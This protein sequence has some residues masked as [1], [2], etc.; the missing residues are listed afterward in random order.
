MNSLDITIPQTVAEYRALESLRNETL[1]QGQSLLDTATVAGRDLMPSEA[2]K[3][4]A[5]MVR[6]DSIRNALE[7][8]PRSVARQ[9]TELQIDESRRAL[10]LPLDFP[11]HQGSRYSVNPFA[12]ENGEAMRSIELPVGDQFAA[13]RT[14]PDG[15][16]ENRS[17]FTTSAG[18]PVPIQTASQVYD[19]LIQGS[20]LLR[21]NVTILSDSNGDTFRW[22]TTSA[23]AVGTA[24]AEGSAIPAS[25]PTLQY[26]EFSAYKYAVI[27]KFS[28]ELSFDSNVN[29]VEYINRNLAIALSESYSPALITGSGTAT[30]QG[31]LTTAGT[32]VTGGTGV[33]GAPT[34]ENI[35]D[36]HFSV[37]AQY[38]PAA[39]WIMND[40]TLAYVAK[41]KDTTGRSLLM[42]S[43]SADVPST[44]MGRP[45]HVDQSVPA[46]G[47]G[48]K[49][50]WFGDASRYMA[51][52]FAG[53]L[54]LDISYDSDFDN[55]LIAIR[56]A[57]RIDSR[58]LDLRAG[59]VFKGGAS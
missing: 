18:A 59:K 21:S 33:A 11:W 48:A 23:N 42:P 41:L 24:V 54:R 14:R 30:P 1:E 55:D 26:I 7:A 29:M 36:L 34:V 27:T 44:L 52:R 40:S 47:L 19:Y 32:G 12:R 51:V 25:D 13:K 8:A 10:G 39:S 9:V 38:R 5:S 49:S 22:P 20:G 31:L 2:R 43:F 15:S 28:S 50:I 3:F 16:I 56:A 45:V 6:V 17:M 53:G 58:V 46:I 57:Q 4:D 37:E 35:I